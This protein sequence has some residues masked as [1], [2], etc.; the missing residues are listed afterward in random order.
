VP[1]DL[2]ITAIGMRPATDWLS[3]TL[4]DRDERG[5]LPV[6]PGGRVETSQGRV[7]AVGDVA[8]HSHP[9]FGQIPGGHWFAAL[10]DPQRVAASIV[11]AELSAGHAPEVFSDQ[12]EHHIEI[13]GSLTGTETVLRGE[14][15]SGSWPMLH[16][17]EGRL[18]G[19]V[20]APS[21]G[22]NSWRSRARN[23]PTRRFHCADY[24][25]ANRRRVPP[26][27]TRPPRTAGNA[28][29]PASARGSQRGP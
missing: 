14:P 23:S 15:A 5:F 24:S 7:W 3:G 19:A 29:W 16:L 28:R 25:N 4:I 21:P 26:Y 13:L 10:R 12:G 11:G 27:S 8:T 20:V 18:L 2:V 1:G 6:D 17:R 9:V 22:Q